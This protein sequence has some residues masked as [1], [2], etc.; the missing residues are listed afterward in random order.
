MEHPV[1]NLEK[2]GNH[3]PLIY[4]EDKNCPCIDC[5]CI[6]ICKQKSDFDLFEDCKLLSKYCTYGTIDNLLK[7]I[8]RIFGSSRY[9]DYVA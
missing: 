1:V 2:K 4:Y 8:D 9:S 5:L 6:P 7:T 3:I